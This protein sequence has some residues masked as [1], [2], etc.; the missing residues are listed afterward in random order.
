MTY[1]GPFPFTKYREALLMQARLR[2]ETKCVLCWE[3]IR[4][5]EIAWRPIMER[6]DRGVLRSQRFHLAHLAERGDHEDDSLADGTLP[7]RLARRT[8]PGAT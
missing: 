1:T 8:A 6:I 3:P 4:V 7:V 2:K 5:G